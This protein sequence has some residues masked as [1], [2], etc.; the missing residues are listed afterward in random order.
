MTSQ[1]ITGF[2]RPKL[3]S[4]D[5]VDML[6]LLKELSDGPFEVGWGGGGGTQ[7]QNGTSESFP[8]KSQSRIP[9]FRS[10]PFAEAFFAIFAAG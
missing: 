5:H 2:Q 6:A 7:N 3:G 9:F 1:D 4:A 8:L 10:H